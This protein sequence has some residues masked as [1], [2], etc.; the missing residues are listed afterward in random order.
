MK[1][2]SVP[3]RARLRW[4]VAVAFLALASIARAD[5]DPGDPYK[6]HYP[7]LP[8]LTP[9]GMD[10]HASYP[11]MTGE[12]FGKI[13]ADDF[14][15][16]ESGPISQIH[17]WG[18]WLNDD[19]PDDQTGLLPDPKNVAFKLSI[20]ADVPVG[21][22][23]LMPWSHPG[24]Q[25]WEYVFAE[26]AP[27]FTARLYYNSSMGPE[28][29]YDPNFNAVIG[30]DTQIWQYNFDIPVENQFVQEAGMIYWLDVQA[31]PDPGNPG[32]RFGW[33][34]TDPNVT[35]HFNDDAVFGDNLAFGA[36]PVPNPPLAPQQWNDLHYPTG[37]PNEGQSIDLAFVIVPEPG[38]IAMLGLGA[39]ALGMA[40]A[41]RRARGPRA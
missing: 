35:P 21:L 27:T 26:G 6:M 1:T 30:I 3:H 13:L 9:A 40:L 24:P 8:D 7:Q 28:Q 10:V 33:K 19:L 34:T 11:W 37:N 25:L 5:W 18:S 14:Q 38:T 2:F 22:D 20:H 36:Q 23:P 32:E 31:W 4:V 17:I 12:P 16:I 39:L 29:F 41:G 15:C